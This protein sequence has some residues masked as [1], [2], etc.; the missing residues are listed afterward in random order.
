MI[1]SIENHINFT[2]SKFPKERNRYCIERKKR[3]IMTNNST[4]KIRNNS[5]NWIQLNF[6]LAWR[7]LHRGKIRKLLFKHPVYLC[8]FLLSHFFDSICSYRPR[9]GRS[10]LFLFSNIESFLPN[11]PNP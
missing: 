2:V 9:L 11:N 1:K 6:S 3:R 4:I 10:S 8:F 5:I 7:R